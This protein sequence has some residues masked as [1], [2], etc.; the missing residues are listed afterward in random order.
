MCIFFRQNVYYLR[1][2]SSA[3][4]VENWLAITTLFPVKI[5]DDVV[6]GLMSQQQLLVWFNHFSST[7]CPARPSSSIE[8]LT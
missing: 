6:Y 1:S 7:F 2:T 4:L 3:V 5:A 8:L